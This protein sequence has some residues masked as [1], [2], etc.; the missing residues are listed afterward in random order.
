[1]KRLIICAICMFCVGNQ[2]L[3]H[4]RMR[5]L[6]IIGIKMQHNSQVIDMQIYSHYLFLE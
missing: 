3:H 1:M 5:A 6:H 4:L 2:T